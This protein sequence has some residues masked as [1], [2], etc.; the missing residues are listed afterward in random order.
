[1]EKLKNTT[2]PIQETEIANCSSIKDFDEKR[3]IE[4]LE[5]HIKEHKAFS[6]LEESMAERDERNNDSGVEDINKFLK[7]FETS[8][9][10]LEWLKKP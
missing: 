4:V 2:A 6:A 8:G 7:A 9:V 5:F 10:L 1:M 3:F